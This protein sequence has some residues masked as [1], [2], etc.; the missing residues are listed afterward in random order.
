[1]CYTDP[2]DISNALNAHFTK[3]GPTLAN[4]I[5]ETGNSF[6]DFINPSMSSFSLTETNVGVVHRLIKSLALNKATGLD[7]ISSRLLR[8]AADIV[9]PSLT[10]IINLSIRSG[11]F[12]DKWKVTKV[13][14]VYKDDIKSEASRY[15]SIS[16]LPIVSKIIE[17]II[18][19]QLYEY[20]TTNNLLA[21]SQHGFRP[22]HST[23]TA[24]LEATNNSYLNIAN[25]LLNEALFLDLKKAF[26]TVNH[27]ILLRKLQ[28]YGVDLH[29]LRWLN[30][31]Y[32]IENKVLLSMG[33][34]LAI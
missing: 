3:I 34:Y 22:Q 30:P 16:I 32:Q 12:P 15:R 33:H 26:D 11:V 8:E 20:L 5:P 6:E 27:E 29:S 1:M 7:G 19:N 24:L 4:S 21:E 10:N 17:K 13:P 2:N 28:S 25:G 31:I 14:P 18:F 9:V 23:V